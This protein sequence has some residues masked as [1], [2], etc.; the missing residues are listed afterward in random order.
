MFIYL[1]QIQLTQKYLKD[2]LPKF[3]R[4]T[5]SIINCILSTYNLKFNNKP[6]VQFNK[7]SLVFAMKH[8]LFNKTVAKK[9]LFTAWLKCF[10]YQ[11]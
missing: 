9:W 1:P 8:K 7:S 4:V 5:L 6:R 11:G 3:V 10:H 2:A